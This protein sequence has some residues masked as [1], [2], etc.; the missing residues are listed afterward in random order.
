M[1]EKT[2]KNEKKDQK[3]H[4]NVRKTKKAEIQA[5]EMTKAR[6][7]LPDPEAI[8]REKALKKLKRLARA[9]EKQI[10]EILKDVPEKQQKALE[11]VIQNTAWMKVQLDRTREII[12]TD[13]IVMTYDNGGGQEGIRENPAFKGY[14]ALW[15]AYMQG[16]SKILETVAGKAAKEEREKLQQPTVLELVREKRKIAR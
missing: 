16:I 2:T 1:D 15:K 8:L 6:G 9:E 14:E 11:P 13:E 7:I 12:A 10:M 3:T 4:E 5:A